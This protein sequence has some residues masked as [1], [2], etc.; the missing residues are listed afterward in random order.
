MHRIIFLQ[1]ARF[2][3]R[4]APSDGEGLPARGEAIRPVAEQLDFQK[5][6]VPLAA[7]LNSDD[8]QKRQA[9]QRVFLKFYQTQLDS[10]PPTL[11]LLMISRL[12]ASYSYDPEATDYDL[13]KTLALTNHAIAVGNAIGKE[14]S[15]YN[16]PE[17]TKIPG[18]RTA[19][20]AFIYSLARNAEVLDV[21][22]KPQ[23]EVLKAYRAG[24]RAAMG[25]P[26][27]I[28]KNDKIIEKLRERVVA[29]IRAYKKKKVDDALNR[30]AVNQRPREIEELSDWRQ[31]DAELK[32]GKFVYIVVTAPSWCP[33]CQ[34]LETVID[35]VDTKLGSLGKVFRI[36]TDRDPS[37][38]RISK[39]D[40]INTVA[41]KLLKEK[42][43]FSGFS[44]VKPMI[45]L[46][47]PEGKIAGIADQK[48]MK[49]P[50]E[51]V[52]FLLEH[53]LGLAPHGPFDPL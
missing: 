2:I 31:I 21:L 34:Q 36:Q 4:Q 9:A 47:S 19:Y 28:P 48:W 37:T 16:N 45:Y 18:I 7:D 46:V 5:D 50:D 23:D 22:Q 1:Y 49:N 20:S 6:V 43:G 44:D 52:N 10:L 26:G 11:A 30:D 35:G 12:A 39:D 14:F 32:K 3:F 53:K 24:I 27:G 41:E 40:D 42:L 29:G 8:V 25:S 51:F 33:P 15:P 13:Q 17:E 38:G